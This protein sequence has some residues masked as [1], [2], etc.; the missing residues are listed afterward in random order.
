MWPPTAE[1]SSARQK[2]FGARKLVEKAE[3]EV[4]SILANLGDGFE[5][6]PEEKEPSEEEIMSPEEIHKRLY[7]ETDEEIVARLMSS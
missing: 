4:V 5:D 6:M 7:E 3:E 1:L 2:A